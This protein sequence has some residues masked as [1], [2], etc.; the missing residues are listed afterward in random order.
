MKFLQ[1]NVLND[2]ILRSSLITSLKYLNDLYFHAK[3]L[4]LKSTYYLRNRAASEIEKATINSD[5]NNTD[6]GDTDSL[7]PAAASC[8]IKGEECGSCQ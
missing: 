2:A 3:K 4:G 8:S 7:D 5:S 6:T 1:L